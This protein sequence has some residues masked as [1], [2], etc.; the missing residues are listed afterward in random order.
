M[1]IILDMMRTLVSSIVSFILLG[2]I[3]LNVHAYKSYSKHQLWRLHVTNNEQVAKILDFRRSAHIHDIN[4]WTEEFRMNIPVS[5][6]LILINKYI[7]IFV[8][9]L[10]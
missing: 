9:L 1:I 5:L 7:H 8:F 10:F 6:F 4:F 2:T 3:A